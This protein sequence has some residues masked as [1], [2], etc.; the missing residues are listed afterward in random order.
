MNY[1]C[2]IIQNDDP[3]YDSDL[4][5]FGVLPAAAVESK[6]A[7][8][9]LSGDSSN[10]MKKAMKGRGGRGEAMAKQRSERGQKLLRMNLASTPKRPAFAHLPTHIIALGN[11][12]AICVEP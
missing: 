8:D 4:D 10:P 1:A 11:R 9:E 12:W 6:I 3:E 5:V 2:T 7:D